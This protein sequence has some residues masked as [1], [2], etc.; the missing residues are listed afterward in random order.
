MA[1]KANVDV[2]NRNQETV[3]PP[4]LPQLVELSRKLQEIEGQKKALSHEVEQARTEAQSTTSA[5]HRL[6]RQLRNVQ[7]AAVVNQPRGE[8]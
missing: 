4:E 3:A 6:E 7:K 1:A 8:L 5:Y 2:L